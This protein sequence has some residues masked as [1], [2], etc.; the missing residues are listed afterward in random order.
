[1][2]IPD[3]L[4]MT[5]FH[6]DAKLK[7]TLL[8][9]LQWYESQGEAD[10]KRAM[11]QEE[12]GRKAQHGLVLNPYPK[13][14]QAA[15]I[16]GVSISGIEATLYTMGAVPQNRLLLVGGSADS[17]IYRVGYIGSVSLDTLLGV[18]DT[19]ASTLKAISLGFPPERGASWLRQFWAAIPVG[20]SLFPVPMRLVLWALSDPSYG[21]LGL[22]KADAQVSEDDRGIKAVQDVLTLYQRWVA[23]GRTEPQDWF[24]FVNP[25]E[26]DVKNSQRRDDDGEYVYDLPASV[27]YCL[28]AAADAARTACVEEAVLTPLPAR[29][30]KLQILSDRLGAPGKVIRQAGLYAS[31]KGIAS[32]AWYEACA[33]ALLDILRDCPVPARPSG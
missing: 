29:T 11:L 25:A 5:A 1:M 8:E 32:S 4:G 2:M 27:R 6:G 24:S 30:S 19:A 20:T 13:I 10:L 33:C 3:D 23:D 17:Q 31:D 9:R 14:V 26:D 22:N 21:I 16:A 12:W 15:D 28:L 7:E 18:P